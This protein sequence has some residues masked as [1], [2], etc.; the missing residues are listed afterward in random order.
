MLLV[1]GGKRKAIPSWVID[2]VTVFKL[3][4]TPIKAVH[5]LL[6]NA[7]IGECPNLKTVSQ[8]MTHD[9]TKQPT[10]DIEGALI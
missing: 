9:G 3:G 4:H 8:S 7:W 6:C 5:S 10:V 1:A 2:W